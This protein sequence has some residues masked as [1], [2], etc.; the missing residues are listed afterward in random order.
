MKRVEFKVMLTMVDRYRHEHIRLKGTVFGFMVQ[1]ETNLEEKWVPV[2]RY[3]IRHGLAHRDLMNKRGEKRK[4]PMFTQNFNE[5][6]TFAEFDIR[7]NWRIYK[8]RYLKGDLFNM[9]E[10]NN[11]FFE[12]NSQLS[13]EFSKYVLD[14]PEIDQLLIDDA[15]VIFLPEFDLELR[16]FNLKI[17]EQLESEGEKVVYVKVKEMADRISSRLHGVEVEASRQVMIQG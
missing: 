17:A 5:A 3:D 9:K 10:E 4:T 1:Y 7:S 12:K 6:L 15:I 14:H 8:E 2:V 16:D 11:K 13:I